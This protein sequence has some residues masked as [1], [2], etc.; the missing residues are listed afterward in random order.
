MKK[1]T[2]KY[3]LQ[4]KKKITVL[5]VIFGILLLAFIFLMTPANSEIV[6]KIPMNAFTG[7]MISFMTMA[8]PVFPICLIMLI[9]CKIY[10][11][12]LEKNGF[13]LPQKKQDYGK[14][15]AALPRER[16]VENAYAKDSV[17]AAIALLVCYLIILGFDIHYL[18][19]WSRVGEMG[20]AKALFVILMVLHLVF[21]VCAYV[22]YRQ[23]NT[24]IYADDVDVT[25]VKK[26]RLGLSS[27]IGV[28]V[29]LILVGAF[30]VA[31][32]H[33]MTKYVYKS[34]HGSYD[35]TLDDFKARATLEVGS[36]NLHDGV[37]D[38]AV[39]S[40]AKGNNFSPELHFKE[41]EG[42]DHYVIYMVDESAN[43]WA[44]WIADDVH[45]CELKMGTNPGQYKGPY[46]PLGSGDHVYTIFVYALK[47]E[48]GVPCDY[49]FD[50]KFL[51]P[52][53]LY[54]SHL[55]VIQKGDINTYGNVIEFGYVSGTFRR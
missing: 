26:K 40:L 52:D 10:L 47:G 33:S 44:H 29:I 41:V 17:I 8:T 20:D 24:V 19:K 14:D 38:L 6:N 25:T 23:K 42:A 4:T 7:I 27:L 13:T 32:A 49:E 31:T 39:T 1:T 55:D 36:N 48:P 30:S 12:R 54:Y 51:G 11:S 45:E 9:E 18:V 2:I 21:P 22:C 5:T 43:Y 15:L 53:D 16:E 35:K 3:D 37:W 46:P 34:R 28:L 50:E